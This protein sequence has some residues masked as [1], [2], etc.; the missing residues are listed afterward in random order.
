MTGLKNFVLSLVKKI[1]AARRARHRQ[2]EAYLSDTL[3]R[4]G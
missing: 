1:P 3:E 2:A 4:G